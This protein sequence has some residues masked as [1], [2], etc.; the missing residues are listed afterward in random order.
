LNDLG[1]EI[2]TPIQKKAY[3]VILSGK[4]VPGIGQTGTG[5]PFA[6]LLP[7]LRLYKYSK[8]RNPHL[9]ILV[10]VR[11]LVVQVQKEIDKLT[12]Y[13]MSAVTVGLYA[14]TDIKT[15][16]GAVLDGRGIVVPTPGRLSD[17]VRNGFLRLKNVKKR[18]VDEV[19]E[20]LRLGFF[21]K[22]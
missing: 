1:Y 6:N 19:D 12:T 5:K 11:E 2:P 8:D 9:H 17:I 16:T 15:R 21:H 4:D 14:E 20:M 18:V 13:N 10:P 3:L 22:F 7:C